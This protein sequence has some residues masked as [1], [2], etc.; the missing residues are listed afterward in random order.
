LAR[1]HIG[2]VDPPLI[3]AVVPSTALALAQ[4]AIFRFR[5][6]VSAPMAVIFSSIFYQTRGTH[7]KVVL[8]YRIYT[9]GMPA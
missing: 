7:K 5:P 3:S 6:V 9:G 2:G 4:S 8:F 1:P